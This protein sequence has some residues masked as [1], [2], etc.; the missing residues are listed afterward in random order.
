MDDVPAIF[1]AVALVIATVFVALP[2]M[3]V[4]SLLVDRRRRRDWLPGTA[5]VRRVRTETRGTSD[6]R[7]TVLV[8]SYEYRDPMGAVHEGEGDIGDQGLAVDG[9]EQT[10]DIL[11]DPLDHARSQVLTRAGDGSL[12]CGVL[13]A[14]LFAG[15][16]VVVA[17]VAISALTA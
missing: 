8:G 10:I 16:G 17:V 3:L 5:V 13:V 7:R 15:I 14:L 9:S 4:R 6:T 1:P 2:V 11:I 12:P